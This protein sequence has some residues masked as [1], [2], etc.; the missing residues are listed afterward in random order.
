VRPLE[1]WSFEPQPRLTW[2]QPN[3]EFVTALRWWTLAELEESEESFAPS[4]LPTLV[5]PLVEGYGP[6]A[7]FDV[8]V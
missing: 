3:A 4:R 5:R 6:S 7:P 2:A 1:P 8:G